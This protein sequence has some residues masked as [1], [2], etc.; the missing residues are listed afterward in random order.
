[1]SKSGA[2]WSNRSAV[3]QGSRFERIS[4]T[5]ALRKV[6]GS[7]A[8]GFFTAILLTVFNLR[9]IATF[10]KAEHTAAE[11]GQHNDPREKVRRRRDR[12]SV[13]TYTYTLPS[14]SVILLYHEG[15][16]ASPLRT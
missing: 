15:K 4:L 14:E 6:R 11:K 2:A 16:L 7:G 1:M 12:V 9:T 10:L 5:T 3:S 8:A 13:N